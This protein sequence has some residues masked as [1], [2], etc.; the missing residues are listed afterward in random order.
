VKLL[1]IEG[2][3]ATVAVEEGV[4][5]GFQTPGFWPTSTRN[6]NRQL[7]LVGVGKE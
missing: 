6:E 4:P 3:T 2:M 1:K 5:T 7:Q